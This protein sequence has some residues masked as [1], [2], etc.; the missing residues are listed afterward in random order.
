MHHWGRAFSV[1]SMALLPLRLPFLCV[2]ENVANQLPDL[3]AMT[4]LTGCQLSL[5][6]WT[7]SL[8]NPFLFLTC[9]L[10]YFTT[11]TEKY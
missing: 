5:L 7:V 3:M 2:I 1:Y 9:L 4:S 10:G 6:R 8:I 11:V